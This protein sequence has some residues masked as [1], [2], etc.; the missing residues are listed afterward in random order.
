VIA[1]PAVDLREGACVQLVGGS[2]DDERIRVP[3]PIGAARRW[4]EAGFARLHV[5]DLDA[6]AGIGANHDAIN[7][8]VSRGS[9]RVSV[10]GGVRTSERVADL[11]AA[12]ADSVVVGT[13][14][15]EDFEWLDAVANG[16]PNRIVVA[17]DVRNRTVVIEAWTKRVETPLAELAARLD[18]L[19]LAGVLVT[20]VHREGL[21]RGPDLDL[22][23]DL[24]RMTRHPVIASGGITTLEDLRALER[25]GASACVI[26][27]ALYSGAL[28]AS[29]VASE[30]NT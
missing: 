28:D 5:V 7:G 29:A 4:S 23:D 8:I 10:G 2:F 14:A 1:V 15:L 3:D 22:V 12:G 30:F 6:A 26:G 17:L 18:A 20:A 27:M 11:L 13:R 16:S 19:P 24:V 9:A 25:R 21:M